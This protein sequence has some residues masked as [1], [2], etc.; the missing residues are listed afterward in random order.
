MVE[1]ESKIRERE[2]EIKKREIE[3]AKKEERERKKKEEE[4]KE[5]ERIEKEKKAKEEEK[6]RLEKI[7]K[8][9]GKKDLDEI[10]R[11]G[12]KQLA[13]QQAQ[14]KKLLEKEEVKM[15]QIFDGT[16]SKVSRYIEYCRRYMERKMKK[17]TEE[18]K[19]Y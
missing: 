9:E 10:L 6:I 3:M 2:I 11:V 13:I 16:L 8:E 7:K 15:P 5:R 14:I 12:Q 4:D 18:D 17:K 1:L 19:I